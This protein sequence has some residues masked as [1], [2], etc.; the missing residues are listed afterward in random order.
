MTEATHT[1]KLSGIPPGR[2]SSH[3][4]QENSPMA[5]TK[6]KVRFPRGSMGAL[7]FVSTDDRSALVSFWAVTSSGDY[8]KDHELG[9]KVLRAVS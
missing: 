9:T 5:K 7:P 1:K 8:D 4:S 6:A 3:I 2:C